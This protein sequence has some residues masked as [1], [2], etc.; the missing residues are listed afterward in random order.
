MVVFGKASSVAF[1]AGLKHVSTSAG[2]APKLSVSRQRR[3]NKRDRKH[4][5]Y[6]GDPRTSPPNIIH[7]NF[8]DPSQYPTYRTPFHTIPNS[9]TSHLSLLH[10]F[11]LLYS[12]L[13]HYLV[14]YYPSRD[15]LPFSPSVFNLYSRLPPPSPCSLFNRLYHLLLM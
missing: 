9:L 1:F 5:R 15:S 7:Q 2:E 10:P 8:Y 14:P 11:C 13:F 12:P 4:T 3:R 6:G